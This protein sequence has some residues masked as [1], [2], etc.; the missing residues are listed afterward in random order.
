MSDYVLDLARQDERVVAA[1][2]VGSLAG[3]GGDRWSDVDLT[4]AVA[5]DADI[6]AILDGWSRELA[7]QFDA[8]HLMDLSSGP[9]LY[10]VYLLPR[11]LQL[12]VSMTPAAEFHA[13]SERFKLVFGTAA[14][15]PTE[16]SG[17][18]DLLGWALL[19]ARSARVYLERG[20]LWQAENYVTSFRQYALNLAC[21]RRG[22]SPSFARGV[23][24]LP[25]HVRTRFAPALVR[26]FEETELRRA[27]AATMAALL[28]DLAEV[29]LVDANLETRIREILE[30]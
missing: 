28:E 3:D 1:A 25:E 11:C 4:F 21:Q 22:L 6:G 7:E 12:D 8:V 30:P 16:Q 29:A 18:K 5:D 17:P 19:Y 26:S 9:I 13:T 15:T 20:R 27:L 23:D 10:R 14:T 24:E 2:V